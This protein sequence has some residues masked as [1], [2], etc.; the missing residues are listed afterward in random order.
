MISKKHGKSGRVRYCPTGTGRHWAIRRSEVVGELPCQ[1]L[2]QTGQIG[3]KLSVR[4]S[5]MLK[6]LCQRCSHLGSPWY[7]SKK[8]GDIQNLQAFSWA[9]T[10]L[11]DSLPPR[12]NFVGFAAF[13]PPCRFI[14]EVDRNFSSMYE[15]IF[16]K[17]RKT[18]QLKTYD[19]F[20]Q[21]LGPRS[22]SD[23]DRL[24]RNGPNRP[25]G[26]L[27]SCEKHT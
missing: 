27:L 10:Y 11:Q 9:T 21:R 5:R 20:K 15:R 17:V 8:N 7:K 26:R 6:S 22:R 23:C 16:R 25:S 1:L 4:E 24:Y 2:L 12:C 13:V 19:K 18:C 3:K 14:G